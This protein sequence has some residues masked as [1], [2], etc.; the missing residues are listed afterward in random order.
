MRGLEQNKAIET[1]I[2]FLFEIILDSIALK[3]CKKMVQKSEKT[4][5]CD[6]HKSCANQEN[7]QKMTDGAIW[8]HFLETNLLRC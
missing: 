4:T 1:G 8:R 2:I 3:R 7:Q 5:K 6:I